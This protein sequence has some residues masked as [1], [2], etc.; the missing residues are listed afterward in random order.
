M[1]ELKCV[2]LSG[3]IDQSMNVIFLIAYV[4]MLVILSLPNRFERPHCSREARLF[5]ASTQIFNRSIFRPSQSFC[6]NM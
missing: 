5:I 4:L 6:G 2:L 1:I 3:K